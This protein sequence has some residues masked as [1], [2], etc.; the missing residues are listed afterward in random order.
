MVNFHELSVFVVDYTPLTPL[1]SAHAKRA[2]SMDRGKSATCTR[3]QYSC[4]GVGSQEL[5]GG[6]LTS[7]RRT[8]PNGQAG[9]QD[10]HPRQRLASMAG[11]SPRSNWTSA[12][13]LQAVRAWQVVHVWQTCRS[14]RRMGRMVRLCRRSGGLSD[15]FRQTRPHLIAKASGELH[16]LSRFFVRDGIIIAR[17]ARGDR[18]FRQEI[19]LLWRQN[20]TD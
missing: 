8:A 6:G 13:G 15:R 14:I 17:I 1:R 2:R 4:G 12:C 20:G 9:T 16:G 10:R 11:K 7:A 19:L 18:V 3:S 5:A